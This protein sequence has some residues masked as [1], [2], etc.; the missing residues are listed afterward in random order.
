[1]LGIGTKVI[2]KASNQNG[3]IFDMWNPHTANPLVYKVDAPIG[4][5]IVTDDGLHHTCLEEDFEVLT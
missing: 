4:Y 2:H 5:E 3:I 1:M